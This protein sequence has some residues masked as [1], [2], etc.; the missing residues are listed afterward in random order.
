M[1][2]ELKNLEKSAKEVTVTIPG[3]VM[4]D[5]LESEIKKIA[6]KAKIRGFRPGKAPLAVVRQEYGANAYNLASE[7]VIQD[8]VTSSLQSEDISYV[9]R[10]EVTDLQRNEDNDLVLKYTV[11]TF[12]EVT[13]ETYKGFELERERY[14]VTDK[15]VEEAIGRILEQRAEFS[16]VQREARTGDEVVIDFKGKID[17]EYFEGG[18]AER[19]KLVLGSGQFIPG[20]EPQLEGMTIGQEKVIDVSFPDDYHAESLKGKAAQFEVTLHEVNEKVTPV[21]T[22]ELAKEVSRDREVAGADEFRQLIRKDIEEYMDSESKRKFR[23]Q[24]AQKLMDSNAFDV[25]E[26]MIQDQARRIAGNILMQYVQSIP[27]EQTFRQQ[28]ERLAPAYSDMAEKQVR[29]SVLLHAVAKLESIDASEEDME[30]AIAEE[31]T[32]A[33]ASVEDTR[34]RLNAQALESIKANII[35]DKVVDFIGANSSV[36]EKTVT[37]EDLERQREEVNA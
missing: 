27:D 20:F 3:K 10:P 15:D 17:G 23:E 36:T 31:A 4:D 11:D 28:M 16:A 18:T 8:A 1:K 5:A 35:E 30:K 37:K 34:K 22:D 32:R 21:L 2:V 7:R 25:P 29:T 26:S 9:S 13:P 33:Q 24:I 12:P 14:E 19:F 6:K